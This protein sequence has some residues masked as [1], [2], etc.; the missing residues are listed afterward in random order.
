M[1]WGTNFLGS[2][3]QRFPANL[4]YSWCKKTV[5]KSITFPAQLMRITCK[6]KYEPAVMFKGKCYEA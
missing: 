3:Y 1:A 2:L 6:G 5:K 4:T